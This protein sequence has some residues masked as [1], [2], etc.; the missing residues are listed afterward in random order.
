MRFM[1]ALA[2]GVFY[3]SIDQFTNLFMSLAETVKG[4]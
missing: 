4:K 3:F 1:M 2:F